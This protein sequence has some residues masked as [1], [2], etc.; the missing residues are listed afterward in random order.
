MKNALR[1]SLAGGLL[2]AAL[3]LSAQEPAGPP[4]VLRIVREDI[5]EG[6]GGAH[7]KSESAFMQALGKTNFS[8]AVIGMS[9]V[10]GTSQAWFLEG[11]SSFAALGDAERFFDSH[12]ELETLDAADGELRNSSRSLI[13]VYRPEMSYGIDKINLPKA[14][15]FNIITIRVRGGQEQEFGE[16]AKMMVGAAAKSGSEQ[17][18][19]TYQVVS[20]APSGTFLLTEP[21]ESLKTMDGAPQRTQAL[22]QALG[23]T[24]MKRLA[25]AGSD[26]IANQESILFAISPAMSY[27]PKAWATA[28]PEFWGPKPAAAVTK[29]PAKPRKTAAEKTTAKK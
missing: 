9:S 15:Y 3:Q 18:V 23:D 19:A 27:P 29:A 26:T 8:G 20:G 7:E 6:R 17:G 25:K 21:T 24:G 4:A 28:D 2:C 1:L 16:I 22:Y 12:P 14:R 11:Y 5:K 13:A 10:T